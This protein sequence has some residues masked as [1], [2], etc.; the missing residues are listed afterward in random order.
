MQTGFYCALPEIIFT[1][2]ISRKI[3]I[4]LFMFLNQFKYMA[5]SRNNLSMLG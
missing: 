5:L 2:T 1:E 4:E 3:S